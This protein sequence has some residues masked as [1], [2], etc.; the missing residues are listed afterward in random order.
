MEKKKDKEL[1]AI[2]EAFND[3]PIVFRKAYSK[4]TGSIT[5]GLLLAQ[6][7]YWDSVMKRE[8]YK[9]DKDFSEEL[10]M[11]ICEFKAAKKK[12]V[13]FVD[14]KVKGIPAKTYYKLNRRAVISAITSLRESIPPEP[15]NQLAEIQPTS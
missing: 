14:I 9:T 5:A 12:I 8:F 2:F 15:D 1:E 11:G 7:A 6:V 4:I 13:E 3:K 10:G